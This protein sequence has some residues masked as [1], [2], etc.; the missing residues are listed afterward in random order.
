M[1]ILDWSPEELGERAVMLP[2]SQPTMRL[3]A[4]DTSV[5]P[6]ETISAGES[7][8]AGFMRENVYASVG[9]DIYSQMTRGEDPVKYDPSFQP[10]RWLKENLDEQTYNGLLDEIDQGLFEDTMSPAHA[11]WKVQE[12]LAEKKQVE[13]LSQNFWSGMAG[14]VAGAVVDPINLVPVAGWFATGSKVVRVG[15]A[16]LFTAATTG[17]QEAALYGTQD[18]RTWKESLMNVGVS[19]VIGGG[20]GALGVAFS[21]SS[22]LHPENVNNPLHPA[23]MNRQGV[24]TKV[25]GEEADDIRY[26]ESTT[27]AMQTPGSDEW[28]TAPRRLGTNWTKLLTMWTPA[29]RALGYASDQA[30]NVLVRLMDLGGVY[31]DTNMFGKRTAPSAEDLKRDYMTQASTLMLK[32]E[33]LVRQ[34]TKALAEVKSA[35]LNPVDF[36]ET[37]RKILVNAMTEEHKAAMVQKYGQEGFNRIEAKATQYANEIHKTNEVFEK[38]LLELGFLRDDKLA[39]KLQARIKNNTAKREAELKAL[40]EKPVVEGQSFDKAAAEAEIRAKYDNTTLKAELDAQKALPA[41]MGRDYGHAQLWEPSAVMAKQEEFN[42]FLMR[43]LI[44]NPEADWLAENFDL[45]PDQFAALKGS[46]PDEHARILREWGGDE[47]HHKLSVLEAKLDAATQAA[48]QA[49]LDFTQT[50]RTLG[51]LRREEGVAKVSEARKFR[52]RVNTER[53]AA[54]AVRDQVVAERKTVQVAIQTGMQKQFDL[55]SQLTKRAPEAKSFPGMSKTASKVP[56]P[57]TTVPLAKLEERLNQLNKQLAKEDRRAARLETARQKFEAAHDA[58]KANHDLLKKVKGAVGDSLVDARKARGIAAKDLKSA[59]REL[60]KGRKRTPLSEAV[61]EIRQTLMSRSVLPSGIMDRIGAE[62]LSTTGRMKERRLVLNREQRIEAEGLGFLR[63][64]LPNILNLQ[65]SQLAG[66]M[67]LREGLGIG[68]GKRFEGW[69]DVVRSINDE[70]DELSASVTGKDRAKVNAERKQALKDL[71]LLK[72][73]LLGMEDVGADRDGWTLWG[74]R[75]FRQANF[76]RFGSGFL[77]PA[78]TDIATVALRHRIVPMLWKHGREAFREAMSS[79]PR[80]ELRAFVNATEI[81]SHG[82]MS[83]NRFDSDDMSAMAGIGVQGT[84]KHTVTATVDR[85]FH[86]VTDA[87]TKYSGMPLWNRFWKI[88][89]GINMTYK[90]RDL[91]ASYDSLSPLKKADLATVGIGQK[92]AKRLDDFMKRFGVDENGHFDPNLEEWVGHPGGEEA[93]R[94]FRIAVQRDMTRSIGTPGIGDTPAI[95]DKWYGKLLLQFQTFAFTFTSRYV[96]PMLQQATHGRAVE[97]AANFGMLMAIGT[98]VMCLKDMMR[99]DDPME[100]L[101]PENAVGTA[102]ELADRSGIMGWT[103]PYVGAGMKLLDL[104][105]GS[106]FQRSKWYEPMLGINAALVGDV[107]RF[108]ASVAEGEDADKVMKKAA[109]LAP[110]GN[111]MRFAQHNFM[112]D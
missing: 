65:Y 104:D 14:Q 41:S 89:S 26:A 109:V 83:I 42:D 50:L 102:K 30:R 77:L 43:V 94:D 12:V 54:A 23:N 10:Y 111:W 56:E 110:F 24:V 103:S 73:R 90:L 92:E 1:Q 81:G 18:L 31:T 9:S 6:E 84:L 95:M 98:I 75:K 29:G 34:T 61:E 46:D 35:K 85:G 66:H 80:S 72:A 53:Q 67:G 96:A 62:K 27:G 37:A 51:I 13:A 49:D 45:T 63:T 40:A 64:D 59:I 5:E 20:V 71:E 17:A 108:G 107:G 4:Q 106:K 58:A 86:A 25:A 82:L 3:F 93:A 78:Q 112:D 19:G 36:N 105:G 16:A 28:L 38:K 11:Q 33:D 68:K 32:G 52:D 44:D 7:F 87:V 57:E 15:K 47:Y 39:E 97:S 48:K 69:G 99:G 60:A 76:L 74:S 2:S 22:A 101:K 91:T 8:G 100:R 88:A 21:K 70:Y 79:V 55:A